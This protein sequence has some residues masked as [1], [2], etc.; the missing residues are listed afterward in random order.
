MIAVIA[1]LALVSSQASAK[2]TLKEGIKQYEAGDIAA[3]VQTIEQV[4]EK[5][6][7]DALARSW[8]G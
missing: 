4:V 5:K 1:L 7:N 3:A 8:L 2:I 6:P